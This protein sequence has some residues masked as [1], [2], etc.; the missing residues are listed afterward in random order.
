MPLIVPGLRRFFTGAMAVVY[1][2]AYWARNIALYVQQ[3][4]V[5]RDQLVRTVRSGARRW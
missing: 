4:C 1:H 5:A 3:G 2:A